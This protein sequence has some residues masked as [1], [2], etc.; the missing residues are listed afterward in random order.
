MRAARAHGIPMSVWNEWSAED[1]AWALALDI[2]DKH[3]ES[4]KCPACGGDPAECQDKANAYA[5]EF[6]GGF[7]YRTKA[8]VEFMDAKTKG[9]KE[10]A[11]V[12]SAASVVRTRLN[13]AKR[14]VR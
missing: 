7:C 13:P 3:R 9:A 12:V 14:R 10:R 4:A 8:A 6:D 1:R 2:L 11:R 5:Y